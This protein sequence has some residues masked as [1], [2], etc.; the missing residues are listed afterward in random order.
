MNEPE[1]TVHGRLT[2]DPAIRYLPSGA[3][4]AE[5]TVA[6]NPRYRDTATGDWKDGEA[7]FLR[8][9]AWRELGE[10]VSETLARGHLVTVS[11]RLRRRTWQDKESGENRGVYEVECDDVGV[12]LRT[13]VAKV[14]RVKREPV[15]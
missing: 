1:I 2:D 14:T 7:V 5:F 8:C 15:E 12:S 4:V 6:Q 3:A 11:G 13:Q 9:K 10:N